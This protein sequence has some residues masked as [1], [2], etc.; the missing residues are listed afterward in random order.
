MNLYKLL[1][2]ITLGLT[3]LIGCT[4]QKRGGSVVNY[5]YLES[6]GFNHADSIV[7]DISDTRDYEWTLRATDS[8]YALGELSKPKYLF[9]RTVTLNMLNQQSTSL[10]L[11]YQLDTLDL[12]ELKTQTD[13]ESYVY[14]YNNY[15]RMLSDMRRYDRALREAYTADKRL[16]SVG[17]TAFTEH[18][19]IAQIIG[20]SQL[21]MDQ[22][23]EAAA[24][25]Q[26][27]LQGI[28]KRLQNHHNLLD[29]RECQKTMNGIA[30]AYMRK[31]MYIEAEPWISRQDSLYAIADKI[32][33]RDTVFLDEMQAEINYSKALLADAQGKHDEAER[34]Y[35]AYQR[36]N[37]AHQLVN[38]VNNNEYLM[39][40]GRYA[41]AARNFER[42]DEFILSND[43]KCDIENMGRYMIPKYRANLL[44]GRIDSALNVANKVAE[45]YNQALADQKMNDAD[46][47]TMVYDTE[48]K[49]RQIAEQRAELSHQRTIGAVIGLLLVIIFFIIYSLFRRQAFR[50]L[51]AAHR[52]LLIANEK[53]EEASRMKAKFIKQI[54][55]EVRTP[56]NVLSGF[57]QVLTAPDFEI[58]SEELQSINK[59][60]VENS[61]R[62]T[63]LVDKMLDLSEVNNF[64]V[65]ECHDTIKPVE[66]VHEAVEKSG[67]KGATHLNFE[68]KVSP[69]AETETF[70]TNRKSVVK[71]LLLLLDN[72]QKFTRPVGAKTTD[73]LERVTL[74][75]DMIDN[76]V[77]FVV[78]DT[79]IGV[80]PKEAEN[81]F[82]EFVQ[83][84][85]YYDGTGIG[86]SI[87]RSLARHM[88]GDVVL[89][90][91][92][93]GGARFVMTLPL[94]NSAD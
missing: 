45:Y 82:T 12:K 55:H 25:F 78:E 17:Y 52:E 32:E 63:R 75:V 15:I 44:A 61:E 84:D 57:T 72:A 31:K 51:N 34:A 71:A 79:G 24:S 19:D 86:L 58:S 33:E 4:N 43:Y 76:Q 49:E 68:L 74:C 92:Y 69:W 14:T 22:T 28:H 67:I 66:I 77:R 90:T 41:E 47:L 18:H 3:I 64:S 37:T 94:A 56:L 30:Q 11:Y 83:L 85:E 20:E 16:R 80:P 62:I 38:I 35:K 70:V 73:H 42:L 6:D 5:D 10:R 39:R 59:K 81:I 36:T 93:T 53:A 46:L 65:I 7:N 21:Y 60:I 13:I 91:T 88:N 26:R 54:S 8:L 87:A 29:L 50:R 2:T 23:N 1:I 27:S 9:Y 40:I 89:D 48:G